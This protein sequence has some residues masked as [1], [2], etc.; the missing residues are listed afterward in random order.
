MDEAN[1]MPNLLDHHASQA[2]TK[3]LV[4]GLRRIRG[5]VFDAWTSRS[6][7][8]SLHRA[9]G[10]TLDDAFALALIVEYLRRAR[11]ESVRIR[12][13]GDLATKADVGDMA[14]LVE[15]KR[16]P[17]WAR[18]S[19]VLNGKLTIPADIRKLLFAQWLPSL[20]ATF[21]GE[22]PITILGEFHQMCLSAPLTGR[23]P[24]NERRAKGAHYT[25]APLVDYMVGRALGQL[26]ADRS[27]CDA[28][29]VL[30]PSCGCGAFLVAV[31]R[32]LGTYRD[33]TAPV[34]LCGSDIDARAVV[35]AG[36]SLVLAAL[37]PR[38]DGR[39]ALMAASVRNRSL[40]VQDFLAIDAW[41]N[42]EFDLIIG[43]PPFIR[44]EQMHSAYP[45]RVREYRRTYST[46]QDGQF[47]LYM[48]FIEKS[49][50]LLKPG[51]RLA[52]SVS[53]GFLRNRS[54]AKL[55][56]F[57]HEHCSVEEIIEFEDDRIY[58]DASVQIAILLASK[59]EPRVRT[60]YALVPEDR[61]VRE[62]LGR[63]Y[64]PSCRFVSRSKVLRISLP[65]GSSDAWPLHSAQDGGFLDHMD[66]VATA[67]GQLPVR[68]SL[69]VC[70]GADG[71][72]LL[73]PNGPPVGRITPVVTRSGQQLGLESA[74][75]RPIRRARQSTVSRGGGTGH[76]CVFPYDTNGEVLGERAFRK[77]YPM[78]YEYLLTH[79]QRL[80]SRRLCPSQAW[81]ALRK[82]DVVSHFGKVKIISPT[83]C[84][85]RG[86]HLDTD[87]V[88]CH[89]SLLTISP[90]DRSID[91]HYLLGI[92]NSELL[93]RYISLRSARMGGER[94]V[95]RLQLARRLPVVF[96]QTR[97]QRTLAARI[98]RRCH[99][100]G[101][102]ACVDDLVRELY[103]M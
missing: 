54:G 78:A 8:D 79:R 65:N 36:L 63:V 48:P 34:L 26:R 73:R 49:V 68:V 18:F 12:G 10:R 71:V 16:M 96:P 55:R 30:D 33:K 64:R 51:G 101:P 1:N 88:L 66:R 62:Q 90:L 42:Q 35:L 98:A 81:Y 84:S 37:V 77:T 102:S 69:G 46:A 5:S 21:D 86:F 19:S 13:V 40:E 31:L 100:V 87:G 91:L 47:D 82:V 9:M 2:H 25:P 61:P 74:A 60:R 99:R 76:L 24:Q 85:A 50:N 7:S 92:L 57:L 59:T 38:A 83:V 4:D 11:P 27:G 80:L 15:T 43:A 53:N 45:D 39:S 22:L 23:G 72:F 97:A 32:Y 6:R 44:V 20:Y 29:R 93:W 56:Q 75:L 41:Q 52:F 28:I 70:T 17:A 95:L 103:G 67:L 3:G 89:H 14:R 94:R 58:P